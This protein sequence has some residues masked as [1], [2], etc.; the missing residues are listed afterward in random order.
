VLLTPTA[1]TPAWNADLDCPP[2]IDG[3][4]GSIATQH[5]FC[6]WVNVLGY[7]GLNVPGKPHPDGRPI[8]LQIVSPYGNDSLALQIGRELEAR[9]PW[10]ECWPAM[11]QNPPTR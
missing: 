3:K 4:A 7:S 8:G 1:A 2:F 11:A 5:M 10:R 9:A 6:G